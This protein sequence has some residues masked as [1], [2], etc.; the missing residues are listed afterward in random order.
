MSKLIVGLSLEECD[1]MLLEEM[2]YIANL[3]PIDCTP[4]TLSTDLE[5]PNKK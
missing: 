3:Q 5:N 4:R 1:K 2:C